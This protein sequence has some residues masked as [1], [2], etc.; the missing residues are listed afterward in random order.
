[1]TLIVTFCTVLRAVM[2]R[3]TV[4]RCGVGFDLYARGLTLWCFTPRGDHALDFGRVGG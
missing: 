1:M 3:A 4:C 2:V